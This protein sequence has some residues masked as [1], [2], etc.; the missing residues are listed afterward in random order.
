MGWPSITIPRRGVDHAKMYK[1]RVTNAAN[2]ASR[3]AEEIE[4]AF[5]ESGDAECHALHAE[6]DAVLQK[7]HDKWRRVCVGAE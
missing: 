2:Y 4:Q 6:M 3:A 7:L 1:K 5:Y